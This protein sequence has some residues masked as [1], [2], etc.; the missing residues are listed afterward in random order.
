MKT[1][2]EGRDA[3]P[4]RPKCAEICLGYTRDGFHWHR[5]THETF[6]GIS[7]KRGDWNW[8]NVQSTGNSFVVVDDHLYFY[9]SGRKGAGG[10]KERNTDLLNAAYAGCSTG[11]AVL[12][13][14][15]LRIDGCRRSTANAHDP[16]AAF[17]R[18]TS[19]RQR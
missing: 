8:G 3:Y 14:D 5:P 9:V 1:T 11:L 13:R 7:E 4:G 15:G 17:Q 6:A 12:R 18:I 10:Y 16:Q 19:V 2:G